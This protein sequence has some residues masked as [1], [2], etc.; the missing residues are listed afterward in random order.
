MWGIDPG[1]VFPWLTFRSLPS[2]IAFL[3]TSAVA[4]YRLLQCSQ[5]LPGVLNSNPLVLQLLP[6]A[7][8]SLW[9]ASMPVPPAQ[10]VRISTANV[11]E[12]TGTMT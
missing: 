6:I 5:Q 7:R 11:T 10:P 12:E 8:W 3:F 4:V 1:G 2:W 9:V